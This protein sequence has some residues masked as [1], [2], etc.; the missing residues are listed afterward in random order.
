M[1]L[2]ATLAA[3]VIATVVSMGGTRIKRVF[4]CLGRVPVASLLAAEL[5]GPA[6][7]DSAMAQEWKVVWTP[8]N[9]WVAQQFGSGELNKP[10][11]K[12]RAKL[13]AAPDGSEAVQIQAYGNE[14]NDL[15]QYKHY[16]PN[17]VIV[18]SQTVRLSV[19]GWLETGY[20]FAQGSG[21]FALGLW[22]GSPQ[23]GSSS[24]ASVI[25]NHQKRRSQPGINAITFNKGQIW[26]PYMTDSNGQPVDLPQGQWFKL[27]MTVTLNSPSQANGSARTELFVDGVKRGE[28]LLTGIKIRTTTAIP[29]SG[30]YLLDMWGGSPIN[31]P[32]FMPPKSQKSWWRNWTFE[33]PA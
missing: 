16:Y 30:P 11:T 6:L 21:K 17:K 1:K 22:I 12:Y 28:T 10:A 27:V 32:M 25:T 13:G 15:C 8:T 3:L 31:D 14:P 19:E 7:S 29:Q 33:I 9:A 26:A 5:L 18:N 23:I 24:H 20:A 4:A 2:I